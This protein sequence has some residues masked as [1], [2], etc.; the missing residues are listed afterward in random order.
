MQ[1]KTNIPALRFPEFEGA[2]VE[3]KLGEI[4]K[5]GN[6]R[7]YKHLEKGDVPV[8]GTGGYMTS[9]NDF[10]YEGE[11]VGI[12]R[13]GTIDKPIFLKGKFWT[14]DTLFYTHSFKKATPFFIFLL[15]QRI[16]WKKYNEASGVPSLSKSTLEKI[17]VSL[18]TLPEQQKIA[19]FLSAVDARIQAL[20][21]KKELL[22]AYKKGL[23][24]QLFAQTLRFKDAQGR[25]FPDWEEKRLGE[26][27]ER[28]VRK[29]KENNQNILTI[30]AQDGLISQTE[31]FNN[32]VA[33][34]DVTGY[35]LLHENDFAYNKSY[36]KGYPMGATK[37]LIKYKKG[38]VSTLYIC[39][40][41]QKGNDPEFYSHY[42]ESGKL[43]K[44]L[45]KIAQEG[46]RNH[47]LLNMSVVEF[48]RDVSVLVPDILEQ[49]K[50]AAFLG[51]MDAAI[52]Q[53]QA[54]VAQM[55]RWKQGLLQQLFV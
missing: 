16:S 8:Y 42:F 38:A 45:Q 5:I 27:F 1:T 15:F 7:D 54:Q 41:V 37:R 44:E 36:S 17:E 21:R 19:A 23:M 34:K 47:G 18:P 31:Y 43:N 49:Q 25:D 3:K 29:N 20:Q 6:G 28:V 9:V 4:L 55:Q 53:V 46:A 50:I 52:G 33:A 14:V 51:S 32:S 2:W 12:G 11:S 22:Q 39:F 13:K 10:L 24:Q 26:V 30:S 35:Y 40:R 48:F